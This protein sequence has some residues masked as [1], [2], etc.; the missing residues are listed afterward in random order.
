MGQERILFHSSSE[1]EL[2]SL[3]AK[4]V[5]EELSSFFNKAEKNENRLLTRKEVVKIL[6]ISFPT[7]NTW[8]KNGII[9][10]LRINGT[11]AVR[12]RQKDVEDAL[13]N[14]ESIKYSR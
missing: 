12:Y 5:K 6:G 4:T 13:K 14:I 1:D 7:L 2:K 8:T 9:K 11:T 3:I 10:A